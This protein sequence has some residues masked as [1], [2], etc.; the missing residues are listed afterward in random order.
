SAEGFVASVFCFIVV[1]LKD[2][3]EPE[4]LHSQLA[5]FCLIGADAGQPAARRWGV[6]NHDRYAASASSG[7]FLRLPTN[8]YANQLVG[9][10]AIDYVVGELKNDPAFEFYC[11]V[12]DRSNVDAPRGGLQPRRSRP[13]IQRAGGNRLC[14]RADGMQDSRERAR[15]CQG[16]HAT[17]GTLALAGIEG[18]EGLIRGA[19]NVETLDLVE[20]LLDSMVLLARECASEGLFAEGTVLLSAG[21][22]SYCVSAWNKDPVSGVIGVQKGPL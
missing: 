15:Y 9:K 19:S 3:D 11:L 7:A 1:P 4:I 14:R 6:G 18:F 12:D 16:V 8:F 20:R 17:D 10:S 21:G 2:N 13:S 22:S 5:Q